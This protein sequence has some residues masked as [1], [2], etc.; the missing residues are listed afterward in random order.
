VNLWA[1]VEFS[2]RVQ[3]QAFELVMYEFCHSVAQAQR[4]PE[5]R[6]ISCRTVFALYNEYLTPYMLQTIK[7][8]LLETIFQ[9]SIDCFNCLISV[10]KRI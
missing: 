6:L 9:C 10:E 4:A 3:T 8:V 2:F 5:G 1:D 7:T